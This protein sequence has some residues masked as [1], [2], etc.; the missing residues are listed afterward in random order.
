G[1]ARVG[2]PAIHLWG[3]KLAEVQSLIQG[4][5][6]DLVGRC[7]SLRRR[8]ADLFRENVSVIPLPLP[9]SVGRS[10]DLWAVVVSGGD[11][12]DPVVPRAPMAPQVPA[13]RRGRGR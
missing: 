10:D 8:E 3:E 6:A 5:T 7:E 2:S 13:R 9:A 4:E 12:P 11:L 1:G